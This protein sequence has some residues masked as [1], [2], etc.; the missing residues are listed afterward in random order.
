MQ[1]PLNFCFLV[2]DIASK[3]IFKGFHFHKECI[4]DSWMKL[5]L[6]LF[7]DYIKTIGGQCDKDQTVPRSSSWIWSQV[8]N[9]LSLV[10]SFIYSRDRC[11]EL[12]EINL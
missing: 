4:K 1:I 11:E 12:G 8:T 6:D 3:I 7:S 5:C 2:W 9:S 10:S